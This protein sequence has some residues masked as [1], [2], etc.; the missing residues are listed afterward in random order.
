MITMCALGWS[1]L[2]QFP[3]PSAHLKTCNY[4]SFATH[5]AIGSKNFCRGILECKKACWQQ[6]AELITLAIKFNFSWYYTFL[7]FF[8][9]C[10]PS[11][12]H[13]F[14]PSITSHFPGNYFKCPQCVCCAV[15]GSGQTTGFRIREV[16]VSIPSQ[17]LPNYVN[18]DVT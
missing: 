17:L 4:S 6:V 13:N 9:F 15:W 10:A 16:C 12:S 1:L 5:S 7:P 2:I 3:H 11:S 8:L 18:M 14:M